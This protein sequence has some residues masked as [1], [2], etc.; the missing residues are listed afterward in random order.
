M[1]GNYGGYRTVATFSLACNFYKQHLSDVKFHRHNE[2]NRGIHLVSKSPLRWKNPYVIGT[3]TFN[4]LVCHCECNEL[5]MPL[6]RREL[7]N[8]DLQPALQT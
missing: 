2:K 4:I 5:H 3:Y 7:E 8:I 6:C 1:D